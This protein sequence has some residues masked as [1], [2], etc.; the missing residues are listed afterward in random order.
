MYMLIIIII[1]IYYFHILNKK[2]ISC[3][4]FQVVKVNNCIIAEIN[5]SEE[6]PGEVISAPDIKPWQVLLCRDGQEYK[7]TVPI[8]GSIN[9]FGQ[10]RILPL[11]AVSHI[12]P[13]PTSMTFVPLRLMD[14]YQ[15]PGRPS[16]TIPKT[17]GPLIGDFVF[18][19]SVENCFRRLACVLFREKRDYFSLVLVID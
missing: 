16:I 1:N 3:V 6:M 2:Y 4:L 10:I 5:S 17:L 13:L 9:P 15:R 8:S 14:N 18:Q 11:I 7:R 19:S 12:G